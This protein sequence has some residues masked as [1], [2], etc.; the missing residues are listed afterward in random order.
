MNKAKTTIFCI[1]VFV[2]T[3][4]LAACGNKGP[5]YTTTQKNAEQIPQEAVQETGQEVEEKKK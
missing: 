2:G 3:S 1:L 5:L 4:L